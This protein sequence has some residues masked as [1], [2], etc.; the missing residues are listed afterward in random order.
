[1]LGIGVVQGALGH[2]LLKVDLG[3]VP[4]AALVVTDTAFGAEKG[5]NGDK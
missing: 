3:H 2:Q 1:V 4:S 5:I